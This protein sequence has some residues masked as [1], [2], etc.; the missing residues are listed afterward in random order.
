MS[1]L[2]KFVLFTVLFSNFGCGIYSFTGIALDPKD[3]TVTIKFFPN[4][5][6]L[7]NPSLSQY[8]TEQL[9]D[10][11][12]S[13][14]NLSLVDFNGDLMFEG[15]ITDYR[16]EPV[17]ITSDEQAE[18]NRLTVVVRVKYTS[19]NNPKY[20]FNTS[21][22]RYA[23]YESTSML[24]DVEDGLNETIVKELIDDIFNKSVVNW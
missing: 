16:T 10:R 14:T 5:A 18:F 23:D 1:K 2:F 4:R 8:F 9:K 15:E 24:S 7:V 20:N 19:I 22:S 11:F 6:S 3:K 21:F 12:V 17:A 13:Q